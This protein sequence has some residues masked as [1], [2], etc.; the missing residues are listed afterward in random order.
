MGKEAI[1]LSDNTESEMDTSESVEKETAV[2]RTNGE[3]PWRHDRRKTLSFSPKQSNPISKI[4]QFNLQ[5]PGV[6]GL[7]LSQLDMARPYRLL[8]CMCITEL[9]VFLIW[10]PY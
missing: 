3:G 1:G 2:G 8:A 7:L 6:A 10:H 4:S 9:V 5:N